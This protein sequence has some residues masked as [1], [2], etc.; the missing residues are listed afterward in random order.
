MAA[1]RCAELNRLWTD[2]YGAV[3]PD[4]DAGKD[5]ARIMAHHLAL[6]SGDQRRR[7]SSWIDS[8]APWMSPDEVAALIGSVL[9][10]PLRWRADTLGKRLNL[11]EANRSRLGITTIGA[12]DMTN[13][14]RDAARMARKR[15]AKRQGRRDQGVKPRAE[16]EQQ[17]LSRAKP[18]EAEG[19]SRATWYRRQRCGPSHADA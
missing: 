7:I 6:M 13:A 14:E 12:A 9:A 8:W 17:S 5:D 15:K 4:D 16:Y 10:K 2:R 18:W 11:T 19:C 3:L 1:L